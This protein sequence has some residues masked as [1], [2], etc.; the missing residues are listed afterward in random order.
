MKGLA[1]FISLIAANVLAQ[2]SS[3]DTSHPFV[4]DAILGAS[5]IRSGGHWRSADLIVTKTIPQTAAAGNTPRRPLHPHI[6]M[7]M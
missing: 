7:I 5:S 4:A 1:I 2:V 3:P 6:T